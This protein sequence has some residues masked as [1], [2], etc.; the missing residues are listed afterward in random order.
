MTTPLEA[1]L[2]GVTFVAVSAC[3]DN[4]PKGLR[5]VTVADEEG[6]ILGVIQLVD[7]NNRVKA[8]IYIQEHPT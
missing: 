6:V 3:S 1:Y 5:A 2:T 7:T 8:S 4:Q